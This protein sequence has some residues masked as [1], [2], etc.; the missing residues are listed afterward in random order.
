MLERVLLAY[1]MHNPA[2]S[3]ASSSSCNLF[4]CT[5]S[6]ARQHLES[7]TVQL[8]MHESSQ[9]SPSLLLNYCMLLKPSHLFDSPCLYSQ[10][11][12]LCWVQIGYCQVGQMLPSVCHVCTCSCMWSFEAL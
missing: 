8:V 11:C 3:G 4:L 1:S 6:H 5:V 7:L 2:V 10:N 9:C 12:M